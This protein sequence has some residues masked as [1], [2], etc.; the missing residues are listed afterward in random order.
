MPSPSRKIH[1]KSHG[2]DSNNHHTLP[3]RSFSPASERHSLRSGATN[4][5]APWKSH[6]IPMKFIHETSPVLM[7]KPPFSS[8]FIHFHPLFP[9][10]NIIIP[11]SPH[12]PF[13]ATPKKQKELRLIDRTMRLQFVPLVT[14]QRVEHLGPWMVW[15][16]WL[17]V[18]S[19]KNYDLNQLKSL[20]KGD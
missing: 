11:L 14:W 3:V 7:V 17:N 1:S 20:K 6:V 16:A 8:M 2:S 18:K 4:G 15:I 10:K 13:L 19:M 5:L 9:N 12:K